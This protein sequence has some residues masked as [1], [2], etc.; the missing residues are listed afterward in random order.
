[1]T[2][3]H[4]HTHT[5]ESLISALE[6]FVNQR[7]RLEFANYLNPATYRAE[8]RF[9]GRQL[10]DARQLLKAVET[11]NCTLEDFERWLNPTNRLSLKCSGEVHYVVGQY[12]ATEYRAA[13]C[14]LCSN[15]L[16]RLARDSYPH[17]DGTELRAF[18]RRRFG[19]GLA[20]RWFN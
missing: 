15:I 2:H 11:S 18:F 13:V 19:K 17:F 7:P 8:V 5:K 6:K 20:K 16:W 14:R 10:A 1:M 3:K 9:V 4:T 12:F